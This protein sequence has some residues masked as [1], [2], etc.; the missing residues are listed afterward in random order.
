MTYLD[1]IDFDCSVP[2]PTTD[3]IKTNVS[4]DSLS[5]GIY[6]SDNSKSDITRIQFNIKR[7]IKYLPSFCDE[8]DDDLTPLVLKCDVLFKE[9]IN[10]YKSK[11]KLP[12]LTT[13]ETDLIAILRLIYLATQTKDL[14]IYKEFSRMLTINKT[15]INDKEDKQELDTQE[16]KSFLDFNIIIDKQ[17]E[18]QTIYDN[19]KSYTNNQHLVLLSLYRFLPER[20]E[21][22][23]LKF[24]SDN[25]DDY[26]DMN[27]PDFIILNLNKSK[28]NHDGI[29][30]NLSSDFPELATVI[31]QS[32]KD[33]P[34]Q[35]VFTEY[36][37]I[38]TPVNIHK[39]GY[40]LKSIF[41]DTGKVVGVNSI[42]SSYL[43]YR[44]ANGNF[45][46]SEKKK[47]AKLMRTSVD[48]IDRSYIK[49]VNE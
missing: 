13:F 45:T 1:N 23:L 12:A 35:F 22:K 37:D 21:L 2:I 19:D 30:I 34:R 16:Q 11:S 28:K 33:F 24:N 40:R 18:L 46:I 15:L 36:N 31:I 38:N 27:N 5:K 17:K 7:F 20:N 43:S 26:I 49:F 9:L 39:M 10:Y 47:V 32:Y 25:D 44:N 4:L 48:R 3:D 8:I 6:H 41:K 29:H 14:P 42:R